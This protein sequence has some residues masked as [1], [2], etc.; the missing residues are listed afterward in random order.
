MQRQ[1]SGPT[2][3]RALGCGM[4]ACGE[5]RRWKFS[6][7]LLALLF[8]WRCFEKRGSPVLLIWH[9]SSS[10]C[11]ILYFQLKTVARWRVRF[12]FLLQPCCPTRPS[13]ITARP[14]APSRL[15]SCQ[16]GVC[17]SG[18]YGTVVAAGSKPNTGKG[19]TL[20]RQA[21]R[22]SAASLEC[23][24]PLLLTPESSLLPACV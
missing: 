7:G 21:L 24:V 12:F 20:C 15:Q 16:P 1:R 13:L 17:V 9:L 14:R 11:C 3:R 4:G 8:P 22:S 10:P 18:A 2:H 6:G 5:H 19:I 23:H